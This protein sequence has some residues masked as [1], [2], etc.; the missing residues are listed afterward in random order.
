MAILSFRVNLP[1]STPAITPVTLELVSSAHFI[2]QVVMPYTLSTGLDNSKSGWR[3]LDRGRSRTFIPEVGSMDNN[4]ISN[5]NEA[6]W[7]PIMN[8]A[9]IIEMLDQPISGPPYWLTLDMYNASAA[10]LIVVGFIIVE[11]KFVEED[12]GMLYEIVTAGE[13]PRMFMLPTR[14]GLPMEAGGLPPVKG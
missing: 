6:G 4:V 3:L 11:E 8:T 1:A 9:Q 13:P 7:A 10:A 14:R 5:P 2:K 12:R